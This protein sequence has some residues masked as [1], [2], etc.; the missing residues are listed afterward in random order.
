MRW[1]AVSGGCCAAFF[2]TRIGSSPGSLNGA[3]RRERSP[4]VATPTVASIVILGWN[5]AAYVDECLTSVLDQDFAEPYEVL[6]VDNGSND[7][8]PD[9]AAAYPGVRVHRLDRNYG[10]CIGNNKGFEETSGRY[11]VFLNQ[12]VVVHRCWLRELV[13]AVESDGTIAAAHANVVQPWY[14]E[15]AGMDRHG[16][17]SV[18]YTADLSRLGFIHYRK[19]DDPPRVVDTLFLHGVSIIVRREL[20]DELGYAFDPGMFAYAEDL[21]LALRTRARGYRTVVAT[22]AT[23]FHKHTLD[24]RPSFGTVRKTVRIIRNRLLAFWKCSTWPEFLPV[25]ALTIIGAPFNAGEFGLSR[26]RRIAYFALLVPP[27]AVAVIATIAAMPSY[28]ARRRRVLDT[29]NMRR[30]WLLRAMWQDRSRPT[31]SHR[32][33]P[34][35][36][37]S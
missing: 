24:T 4:T 32:D 2:R 29:R 9:R 1:S 27:A 31:Q 22:R 26:A 25:A 36:D 37:P 34:I 16:S 35:E 11:I 30:W 10:Y 28:A 18:A 14:P 17:L 33:A 19:L 8:T 3:D 20:I 23:V 5:G 12:D 13:A 7:G 21:D 6:F 15:F